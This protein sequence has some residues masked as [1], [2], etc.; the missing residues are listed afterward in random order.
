MN[1]FDKFLIGD[2][3]SINWCFENRHFLDRLQDN[4]ISRQYVVD[5]LMNEEPIKYEHIDSSTYAAVYD[6]PSNKDYKEIR[7]LMAVSGNSIDLVTIMRN[8]ET[9]TE[10]QKRQYQS[11]KHKNIEKK[12]LN[13][14]S[15]RKW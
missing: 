7:I 13:A 10:R 3:S 11:Q 9:T 5:C 15:K 2:T 14:I 12:R 8:N 6:A 4:G 1:A